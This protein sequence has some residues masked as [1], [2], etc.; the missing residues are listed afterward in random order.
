VIPFLPW[1]SGTLSDSRWNSSST[2]A[3]VLIAITDHVP[4]PSDEGTYYHRWME[5]RP[6]H[7]QEKREPT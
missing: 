6:P 5:T 3:A 1:H 2:E 4:A 7:S